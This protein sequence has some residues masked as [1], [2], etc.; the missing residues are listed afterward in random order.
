MDFSHL[1]LS[2]EGR[3][4][5][6]NWWIGHIVLAVIVLVITLIVS[7]LFGSLSIATRLINFILVLVLAYPA[8]AVSAKRFQDRNKN[9]AL[10]AILIAI[11]IF[12]S[13]LQLFGIGVSSD[14][15]HPST[16]GMILGIATMAV[17]IWYLIELGILRGTVGANQ[18]GPDPV[19]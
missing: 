9:G 11:S 17:G 13:L 6:Q 4:G 5:R 1:Y 10:G 18:Y 2:T 16:F 19:G 3:I 7:G 8:Y 12:S 15:M 14:P